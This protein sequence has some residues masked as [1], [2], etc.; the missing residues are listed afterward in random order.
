MGLDNESANAR[1][2]PLEGEMRRRIWWALLLFDNRVCEMGDYRAVTLTPSWNCKIPANLND[3][4]L[5]A[6]M[7]TLPQSHD[8]P[9]ETTLAVLRYAVADLVRHS[10]FFL[11]FTNPSLKVLAKPRDHG[12]DLVTLQQKIENEYL[13]HLNPENPH[14]FLTLW[15]IRGHIAR[16]LLFQHFA[17]PPDK[18]TQQQCDASINYALTMLDCYNKI[19]T[20]P[21]TRRHVWFLYFHYPFPAFVHILQYLKREPL[22]DHAEACWETMSSS[23]K[24][25]FAEREHTAIPFYKTPLFKIFTRIVVKAWEARVAALQRQSKPDEEVPYIVEEFKRR[26]QGSVSSPSEDTSSNADGS[27]KFET[28]DSVMPFPMMNFG[29]PFDEFNGQGASELGDNL[30]DVDMGALDLT[31]TEWPLLNIPGA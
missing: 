16:Y 24:I 3:S 10:S 29:G 21:S 15:L 20:N 14:H 23:A 1:C 19:L 4:D 27:S 7:K 22:A 18:Q 31:G 17:I 26:A 2:D 5:Q 30:M 13:R 6:E 25:R 11:D 8:R 12:G 28:D 9:T